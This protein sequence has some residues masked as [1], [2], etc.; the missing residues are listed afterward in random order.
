MALDPLEEHRQSRADDEE[1]GEWRALLNYPTF[2]AG[3]RART[4]TGLVSPR[5]LKFG[6]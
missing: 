3:A 4:G 5:D 2:G 6:P 1:K